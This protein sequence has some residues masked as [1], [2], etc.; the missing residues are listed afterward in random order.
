LLIDAFFERHLLQRTSTPERWQLWYGASPFVSETE[1]V[2]RPNTDDPTSASNVRYRF[3][4]NPGDAYDHRP[5]PWL[6]IERDAEMVPVTVKR[7][8]FLVLSQT[9]PP[10]VHGGKREREDAYL[11]LP[12][13]SFHPDDS[14]EFTRRVRQWEFPPLIHIPAQGSMLNEGY[15]RVDRIHTVSRNLMNPFNFRLTQDG[16]RIVE[17]WV[18][19]HLTGEIDPVLAEWRQVLLQS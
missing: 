4:A 17:G 6:R 7:R 16:I 14:P 8:P 5:Y 19:Y 9:L 18:Q 15:L 10:W 11:V 2:L 1:S 13:F 3:V 12:L